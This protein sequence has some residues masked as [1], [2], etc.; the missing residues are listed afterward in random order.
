MAC[1]P[2]DSRTGEL[3]KE[4]TTRYKNRECNNVVYALHHMHGAHLTVQHYTQ[5][6][7]QGQ[8]S[9]K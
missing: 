4:N 2:L 3:E 9:E 7:E 5:R 8:L 1:K 6:P